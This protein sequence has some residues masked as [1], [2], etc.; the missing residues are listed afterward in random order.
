M[1][2]LRKRVPFK[3][4]TEGD[5]GEDTRILD[6][7]EQDELIAEFRGKAES[8][9]KRIYRQAQIYT[10][11]SCLLHT[12]FFFRPSLL[13]ETPIMFARLFALVNVLVH[14]NLL[15]LLTP[16]LD[17]PVHQLAKETPHLP[18]SPIRTLCVAGAAPIF[19]L[20]SRRGWQQTSWWSVAF[21]IT[22]LVWVM[23]QSIQENKA[24]LENLEKLKYDAKG[25]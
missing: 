18:L 2:S 14:V 3:S 21:V 15:L 17:T 1:E 12:I 9:D 7:Q 25:A 11:I 20:I 13:D 24:S 5:T 22:L 19:S 6:E 16:S 8:M 23:Q 4:D 10:G